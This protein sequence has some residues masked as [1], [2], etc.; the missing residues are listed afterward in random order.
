MSYKLSC[1]LDDNLAAKLERTA[2]I[3]NCSVSDIV[4]DA[5]EQ[6]IAA[7]RRDPAF[8]TAR[9]AWLRSAD[10][11]GPLPTTTPLDPVLAA[12]QG[13]AP[14]REEES[15]EQADEQASR[16]PPDEVDGQTV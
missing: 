4:R 9:A 11:L 3:L 7:H 8:Q 10:D 15:D 1:Q 14:A 6:R 16:I 13:A 5:L 12:A 2:H